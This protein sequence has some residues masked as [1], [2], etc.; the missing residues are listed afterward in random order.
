M[1][2]A[3]DILLRSPILSSSRHLIHP[4]VEEFLI[5][6]TESV[7]WKYE[8][9]LLV[10]AEEKDSAAEEA[11]AT[12]IHNHF[13]YSSR[14]AGFLVKKIFV[15]GWKSLAVSFVFLMFMF[16]IAYSITT[17]LP[18]N[19]I[20]ITFRELFIILGWVALWRPADLL[21]Y[22]WREPK[23]RG[24]VSARLARAEIVFV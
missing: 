15:L 7:P 24:K 5:E 10:N 21:L 23:R 19:T 18:D 16:I 6:E 20:M 22:D 13:L 2:R 17:F 1:Q 14:N 8:I 4:A 3:Q 12:A 11:I 9:T